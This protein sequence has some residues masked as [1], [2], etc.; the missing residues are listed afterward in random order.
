MREMPGVCKVKPGRGIGPDEV[1]A[2]PA[3]QAGWAA[4]RFA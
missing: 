3:V 1:L 4:C 2:G